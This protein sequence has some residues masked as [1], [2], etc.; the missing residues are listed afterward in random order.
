M[1]LVIQELTLD[2]TPG[3]IPP[4]LNVTEY[5]E[6]MQVVVQLLQRGQPFEIPAGTTAKVEGTLAGHPFSVDA[7][8]DGSTVTFELD[9][10]MTAFSGRAW[11]KIKLTKD[12]KPVQSCGFWMEVDSAGVEAGD[13]IGAPG[14]EEQIVNAVNDWLDLHHPSGGGGLTDDAKQ[15]LLALFNAIQIGWNVDSARE[16][17]AE[18]E[19]ALYPPKTLVSISAAF[20]QG[21]AVI[22]DTDDLDT[23]KQYLTVTAY[24]DDSSTGV[25]TNY[26]LSGTLT[27]GT[28][29]ITVLYNG[30]T[31]TFNVTVSADTFWDFRWDYT[32]GKL[33]DQDGWT[34]DVNTGSSELVDGAERLTCGINNNYYQIFPAQDSPVR[35]MANGYGIL[36]VV[37]VG[38][39]NMSSISSGGFRL[40][41]AESSSN[42]IGVNEAKN[43]FRIRDAS[44]VT[45][46]TAIADYTNGTEYT[47]R[48]VMKGTT[49]DIYINGT[50][51]AENTTPIS[52]SGG[53]NSVFVDN[54]GSGYYVDLKSLKLKIGSIS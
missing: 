43:K 15:A 12:S 18:L 26:T 10:S 48:L 2:I 35:N 41:A 33:E 13:V 38:Q 39:L 23:L 16:L 40:T 9:K 46:G 6:N 49:V 25:V 27:V 44:A 7:T 3:G 20:N 50:L 4:V 36:E 19:A 37:F 45:A 5:D 51:V 24:Y 29:T 30:K 53:V 54:L 52:Q 14:F 8:V 28:S 31:T 47:V 34:T 1:A 42:R 32:Q 21:S 11:T 22:Y 17:I